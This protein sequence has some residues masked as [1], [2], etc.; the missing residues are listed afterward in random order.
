MTRCSK[1]RLRPIWGAVCLALTAVPLAAQSFS[2]SADVVVVEVPVQVVR[3]GEPVRGLT[4]G[5]FEVSDGRNKV[6]VTGFEVLDLAAPGKPS[7]VPAAARRHFLLLFDLTFSDPQA[8]VRAREAARDL[9]LQGLHGSDLVALATYSAKQGTQLVLGF[10]SDRRQIDTALDTLGLAKLAGRSVDPLRLVL[11]QLAPAGGE[12][13]AEGSAAPRAAEASLE[14]EAA[15]SMSMLSEL[16]AMG[17]MGRD[18]TGSAQKAAIS[19]LTRSFAGLARMM[20]GVVGRKHVV[21]LSEGFDSSITQGTVA[22][23]TED[24]TQDTVSG[25]VL[26]ADGSMSSSESRFGS[27]ESLNDIE[28]ML[29]EFRRADCVIQAVDIGGIRAG[30]DQGTQRR[31]GKDSLFQMARGTGGELYENAND[32]SA[33]MGKMLQRTGVTYVLSFQPDKLKR[34]GSYRKLKVELKGTPRG[35]RVLHRPGYYAPKPYVDMTPLERLLETATQ[36]VG[37][38][39]FGSIPAAVLAA[40]FRAAGERAYVPVL[41]EVDGAALLAGEPGP[42]LPL[43]IYVYAMDPA[44]AVVDFLTQTMNL[45]V[46]KVEAALR[47]SGIK[48]FGHVD[49]PPG[50]YSLRVLVR[51]G[52]T[53]AASLRVAAL[54][55]P[56]FAAA[57]P[58]LLPPFFPEPPGRWMMVREA[59]RGE[60]KQVAYPFMQKNQPY[61]PAARPVVG[62]EPA[63]V[64]LVGYGLAAGDLK[65]EALVLTRD[66][67]EVGP[68][69]LEVVGR[70][71][72][73][74]GGGPDRLAATFQA[75]SLQP[76]EYLLRVTLTDGAGKSQ[77]SAIPFVVPAAGRGARG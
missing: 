1:S 10:T 21:Y 13:G 40:P 58:V 15:N 9:V 49:L 6:A 11:S 22:S 27:T 33:V 26:A 46:A 70:E 12:G 50:S 54:E 19:G 43:E 53:G 7:A 60:A 41:I 5:D 16:G 72:G 73:G 39:E 29:E 23:P 69:T 18:A 36:L 55:V 71:G 48:F 32:L 34:D 42:A 68:G 57:S 25:G 38:E 30:G 64:S 4:A 65:A 66:G 2:E 28:K 20:G 56:A 44:G 76:G 62:S 75:P 67:K 47:Q 77:T 37:G 74:G 3:D 8:V 17:A 24:P 35:T 14:A 63:A 52:I 31:G 61:V 59:P 45:D 51:N